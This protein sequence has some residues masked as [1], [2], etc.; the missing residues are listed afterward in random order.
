MAYLLVIFYQASSLFP[1]PSIALPARPDFQE[2]QFPPLLAVGI[3]V[4]CLRPYLSQYL[5]RTLNC[6]SSWV[7][8]TVTRAQ[9]FRDRVTRDDPEWSDTESIAEIAVSRAPCYNSS[10]SPDT[11]VSRHDERATLTFGT[12]WCCNCLTVYIVFNFLFFTPHASRK[13]CVYF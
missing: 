8:T 2:I 7:F 6:F 9:P 3:L 10:Q 11:I 4:I 5:L 13:R 12:R 1:Y